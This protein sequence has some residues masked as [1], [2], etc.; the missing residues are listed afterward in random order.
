MVADRFGFGLGLKREKNELDTLH[1]L[2]RKG[3]HN[4]GKED[5]IDVTLLKAEHFRQQVFEISG[6]DNEITARILRNKGNKDKVVVNIIS[7]DWHF[8]NSTQV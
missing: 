2:S 5:N 6:S 3:D 4:Q 1:L 7:Y 8:N